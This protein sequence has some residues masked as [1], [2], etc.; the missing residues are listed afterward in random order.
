MNPQFMSWELLVSLCFGLVVAIACFTL[1]RMQAKRIV[2][3]EIEVGQMRDK[4]NMLS[5]SGIGVGRKVVSIDQRLKAAELKQKELQT[6]DVQKVS[7]NEA[8]RLLS[9]GAEVEDLVKVCGLTRAE[10][11]LIKALHSSQTG[12]QRPARH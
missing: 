11:D 2:R 10:A 6:M 9:L 8:A 7:Y 3:L 12:A 4:L 5:D 1:C